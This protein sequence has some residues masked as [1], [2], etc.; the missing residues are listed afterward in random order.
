MRSILIEW[1]I[2]VA[3]EYSLTDMT[4]FLAVKYVDRFLSQAEVSRSTLQLLGVTAMLIA[5]Y[6]CFARF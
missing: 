5:S 2:E 3:V 4:L 6:G 1:L